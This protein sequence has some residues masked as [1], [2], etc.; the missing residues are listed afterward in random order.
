MTDPLIG[1]YDS[2][3]VQTA[4]LWYNPEII[5]D[6]GNKSYDAIEINV[7]WDEKRQ[8]VVSENGDEVV[9]RAEIMI[10]SSTPKVNSGDYIYLGVLNDLDSNQLT[11]PEGIG[12][13]I[14]TITKTP[15]F[16]SATEFTRVVNI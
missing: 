5:D 12:Y 15:L 7:R 11:D 2:I 9:S 13:R 1:F 10:A 3:C 16:Q 6:F 4:V 14:I 8:L